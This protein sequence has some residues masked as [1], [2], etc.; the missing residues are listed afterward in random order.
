M[1]SFPRSVDGSRSAGCKN[2][3]LQNFSYNLLRMLLY[4]SAELE[5]ICVLRRAEEW[6]NIRSLTCFENMY[7]CKYFVYME[8]SSLKKHTKLF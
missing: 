7:R 4:L 3:G 2:T 5:F 6:V 8:V 1:N